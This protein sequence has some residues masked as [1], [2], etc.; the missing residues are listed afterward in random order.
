MNIYLVKYNIIIIF[1]IDTV[2]DSLFPFNIGIR[3]IDISN[4]VD[5]CN[6]I[7]VCMHTPF[8]DKLA[9]PSTNYR[10]QRDSKHFCDAVHKDL[11]CNTFWSNYTVVKSPGDGHCFIHSAANSLNVNSSKL[12][13]FGHVSVILNYLSDETVH[14][15]DR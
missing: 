5:V 6:N 8:Q 2:I 15:S 1:S 4:N 9:I 12:T 11:N 13:G 14:N 10:S 3:H 7:M